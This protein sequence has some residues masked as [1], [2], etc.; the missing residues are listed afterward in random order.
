[1]LLQLGSEKMLNFANFTQAGEEIDFAETALTRD[2]SIGYS[3]VMS[4]MDVLSFGVRFPEIARRY[5]KLVDR[6]QA[7]T[8]ITVQ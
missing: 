5:L 2:L 3:K 7:E 6:F 1:M 8:G 4:S